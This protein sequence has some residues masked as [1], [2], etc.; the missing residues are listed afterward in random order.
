MMT[1]LEEQDK[2]EIRYNTIYRNVKPFLKNKKQGQQPVH[3][4]FKPPT[5]DGEICWS[6]DQHVSKLS[7]VHL[8]E[9]YRRQFEATACIN[10]WSG[11]E[12]AVELFLSL[13]GKAAELLQNLSL[14]YNNRTTGQYSK[15][16]N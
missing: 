1:N 14:K 2:Q 3:K 4:F 13:R 16:W 10:C 7:P 8:K 15:L 12:K 5:F 9:I 6:M 11:S